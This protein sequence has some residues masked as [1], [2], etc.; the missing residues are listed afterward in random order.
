MPGNNTIKRILAIL[1]DQCLE[2]NRYFFIRLILLVFQW[3]NI[4]LIV[5]T[6]CVAL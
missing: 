4:K 1:T 5:L 2:V 3:N 6:I